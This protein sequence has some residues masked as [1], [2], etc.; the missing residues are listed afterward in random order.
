MAWSTRELADL[1]GTTVR[2]VRHYH[3]VGL[4]DEPRRHANGYKQYGVA[5]LVRA[6]RIRRLAD[7][8]FTLPQIAE[9]GDAGRHP[10]DALR[11]LDARLARSV[12]RLQ[13]ARLELRRVLQEAAP[14]DLLPALATTV[15]NAVLSDA[16]RSLL[17]VMS[18]V[19]DPTA[20]TALVDALRTLPPDAAAT[21]F[22]HLPADT[23]EQTRQDLAVSLLPRSRTVRAVLPERWSADTSRNAAAARTI[24]E[25]VGDLYNPAQRDVV[26]RIGLLLRARH[27]TEE[28]RP[29]AARSASAAM[30][31]SP[32]W[33]RSAS[34]STRTSSSWCR[35]G[36]P[37]TR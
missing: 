18:R 4:L 32:G 10:R 31:R 6:V 23:D 20:L 15:R 16:D 35:P 21:A 36:T 17:V 27:P 37:S 24:A 33:S 26:R 5:H 9:L 3:D 12:D 7:L 34:G 29:G 2:A 22:D 30:T 8:G 25:A 13:H 19:L 11:S 14:V 1:A 28:A